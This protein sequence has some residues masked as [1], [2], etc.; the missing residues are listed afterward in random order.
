MK[1]IIFSLILLLKFQ[2]VVAFTPDPYVVMR[3]NHAI[4][5]PTGLVSL[6]AYPCLDKIETDNLTLEKLEFNMGDGNII[7]TVFQSG[8]PIDTMIILEHQYSNMG[9]V[10]ITG[11]S[12]LLDSLGNQVVR[13]IHFFQA[14]NG[15]EIDDVCNH[16]QSSQY[17]DTFSLSLIDTIQNVIPQLHL[18]YDGQDLNITNSS[19]HYPTNLAWTSFI[20]FSIDVNGSQLTSG[21]GF[22]GSSTSY[23]FPITSSGNYFVELTYELLGEGY[24]CGTSTSSSMLI[25]IPDTC[26][27]CSSFIPEPG[28]RYW[29][30]SWVK[31]AETQQVL[32]YQDVYVEVDFGTG[33]TV[34]LQPTGNII[35]G[36]QRIAGS[37]TIPIGAQSISLSLVNDNQ[38]KDAFFDDIRVHPFN[39]SMKSY[40]YDPET[41]WLT[42]ELDDNNY[43][44]FYEYDKEG[45]LI[46]IK[47]E[48]SRGVMTIQES[49]SRTLKIENINPN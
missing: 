22:P 27:E 46:R 32:N 47:K 33:S 11:T 38:G 14:L 5:C 42:A 9:A 20:Q 28:K 8:V 4:W 16:I 10:Q 24:S 18:D 3:Y 21:S 48:T 6:Q 39:G 15:W 23:P 7:D 30:S 40:V 43:A 26:E 37:F 41:L 45:Q 17:V 31:V 25:E 19:S 12:Y 34:Q 29:L 36:W 44:T 2:L 13:D 49:R 1:K 35:E